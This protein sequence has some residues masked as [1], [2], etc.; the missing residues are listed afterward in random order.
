MG[1]RMRMLPLL[2]SFSLFSF[3][4]CSVKADRTECPCFLTAAFDREFSGKISLTG[5]QHASC[6]FSET[7][8]AN[9]GGTYVRP[10]ERGVYEFCAGVGYNV[11]SLG[12]QSDSLYLW[13]SEGAVDATGED[14]YL[15][16]S[17][18]KQFAT[19]RLDMVKPCEISVRG[20]VCGVDMF[21]LCPLG[22]DFRYEPPSEDGI[23]YALRVPRQLPAPLGYEPLELRMLEGG[24]TPVSIPLGW[25]IE[26]SG[27][28]WTARSLS[29]MEIRVDY[30]AREMTIQ[31]L[32]WGEGFIK[33]VEF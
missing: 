24:G 23:H 31:V 3:S 1:H 25:M 6:V 30:I 27:Y 13:S 11:I 14:V 29:D 19:L 7:I 8:E 32:A 20:T 5:W 4:A 26:Q 10:I 9:A 22:G 17:M 16:L 28:D 21:T 18:D 12:E 2:A 15:P 33:R